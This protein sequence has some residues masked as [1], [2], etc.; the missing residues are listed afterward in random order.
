MPIHQ[1]EQRPQL[2]EDDPVYAQLRQE[3]IAREHQ[4]LMQIADMQ[5]ACDELRAAYEGL[6]A[7]YDNT[8]EELDAANIAH[9]E[10]QERLAS[11][12]KRAEHNLELWMK[13][14]NMSEA[15]A[16]RLAEARKIERQM[17]DDT[18]AA[19]RLKAALR[20]SGE[21]E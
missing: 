6:Q 3:Y 21:G 1:S 10:L 18:C 5:I 16:A 9:D 13:C 7:I 19:C 2:T 15:P 14:R 20:G 17:C 8:Q 4:L 12:T 11:E